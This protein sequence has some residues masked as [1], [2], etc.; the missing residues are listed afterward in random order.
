MTVAELAVRL[1]DLRKRLVPDRRLAVW[2][3]VLDEKGDE[4]A[5]TGA[6]T[7]PDVAPWPVRPA[8]APRSSCSRRRAASSR[9][10]P[11]GASPIS[12]PSR[13]IRPSSSRR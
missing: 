9:R 2:D 3:V 6:V 13:A 1:E 7:E 8:F 12:V 11:I 4:P 10:R 5:I